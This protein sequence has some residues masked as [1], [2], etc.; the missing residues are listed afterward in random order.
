MV[1][2]SGYLQLMSPKTEEFYNELV[3]SGQLLEVLAVLL[4]ERAELG[5]STVSKGIANEYEEK[6]E[7]L[8]MKV[9]E[10]SQLLETTKLNNAM[11][12]DISNLLRNGNSGVVSPKRDTT[13]EL[14]PIVEKVMENADRP[15]VRTNSS[16][17]SV[18]SIFTK[19]GGDKL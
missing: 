17:N 9:S 4:H 3:K 7:R 15:K 19:S 6:I 2:L 5:I 8:E 12:A 11:L 13:P 1:P 14:G 18:M 16:F 10:L